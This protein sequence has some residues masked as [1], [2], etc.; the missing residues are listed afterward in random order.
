MTTL[1]S[2]LNSK[3]FI[4]KLTSIEKLEVIENLINNASLFEKGST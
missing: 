4:D 2:K 1:L 3:N